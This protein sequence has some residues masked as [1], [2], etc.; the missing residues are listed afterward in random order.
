MR[1]GLA[2]LVEREPDLCLVGQAENAEDAAR[3]L[4]SLP[5]D[6][7]LTDVRLPGMSGL[8]LIRQLH[9]ARPDLRAFVVSARS[10]AEDLA[11]SV[12][13]AGGITKDRLASRLAPAIREALAPA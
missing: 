3:D 5:C 8:D 2:R 12:G 10:D 11:R 13:A 7:V 6:L 4:A 9:E 1:E